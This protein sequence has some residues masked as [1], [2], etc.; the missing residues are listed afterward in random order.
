MKKPLV[1]I[2]LVVAS[3]LC[4][5]VLYAYKPTD[6]STGGGSSQ[7]SIIDLSGQGMREISKNILDNSAATTLD[8]SNNHLTGALPA[9]IRKLTKLEYLYAANNQL[10][11]IPAEIGQLSSLKAMDFSH[12]NLSGLPLEISNLKNLETLDLR[13]NP[14]ISTHD[15]ALIRDK[16]PNAHILIDESE[17]SQ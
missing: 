6:L 2:G 12:N 17:R 11:G 14:R 4:G 16:I 8:V 9:E 5:Y 3:A 13:G 15:V 7:P 10:T 1:I